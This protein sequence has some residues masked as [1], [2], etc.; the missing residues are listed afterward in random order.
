[1]SHTSRRNQ[2]IEKTSYPSD[3]TYR[4]RGEDQLVER[5]ARPSYPALKGVARRGLLVILD[6]V[7]NLEGSR[8]W[9]A[10]ELEGLGLTARG[11]LRQSCARAL[12]RL[13]DLRGGDPCQAVGGARA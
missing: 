2:E 7:T 11:A 9:G 13:L 8:P 3:K 12:L 4:C 10:G 5:T 6:V 1:M